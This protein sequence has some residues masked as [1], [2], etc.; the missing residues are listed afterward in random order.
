MGFAFWA[1]KIISQEQSE[2][3]FGEIWII[4]MHNSG[5]CFISGTLSVDTRSTYKGHQKNVSMHIAFILAHIAFINGM[6]M[7]V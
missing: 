4:I 1:I 5:M 7:C 6:P 2:K 3:Q